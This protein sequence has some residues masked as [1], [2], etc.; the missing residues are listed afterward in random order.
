MK[1]G[2]TIGM[3][4]GDKK[5]QVCILDKAGKIITEEAIDSKRATTAKFFK[6]YRGAVV[7]MEAIHPLR[8]TEAVEAGHSARLPS[9]AIGAA[10]TGTGWRQSRP[11]RGRA[12]S[13]RIRPRTS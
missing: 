9:M 2:I 5:H 7:A 6:R 4:L 11:S 1:K 10:A 13:S 3:D 8:T 12:G